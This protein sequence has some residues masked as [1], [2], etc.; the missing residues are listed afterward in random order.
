MQKYDSPLVLLLRKLKVRTRLLIFIIITL[1]I[2]SNITMLFS[3]C[4]AQT[5]ADQYV[6]E[7]LH[8]EH[9]RLITYAERERAAGY[10]TLN[11]SVCLHRKYLPDRK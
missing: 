8:D 11:P 3:R 2:I 9:N 7:Y 5:I 4:L 10:S 6:Y 1:L